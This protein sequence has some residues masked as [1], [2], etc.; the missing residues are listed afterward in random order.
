MFSN[1]EFK[2]PEDENGEPIKYE[3]MVKRLAKE[4]KEN[5][6]YKCVHEEC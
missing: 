1:F 6:K 4:F 2:N 5:Q 3:Y